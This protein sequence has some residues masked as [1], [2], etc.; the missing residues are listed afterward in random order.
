[1]RPTRCVGYH[2]AQG[3]SVLSYP[4]PEGVCTC[5]DT[6]HVYRH[7]ARVQTP[8]T[9]ADTTHVCRNHARVQTPRT[10]ADIT[11]VC[12]HHRVV[13]PELPELWYRILRVSRVLI[14]SATWPNDVFCFVSFVAVRIT[15]ALP[16]VRSIR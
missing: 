9:C 8:H 7:H 4:T 3:S 6:M 13:V 15:A 14:R 1:M 2:D 11:H 10:C 12:R 5:V 16:I